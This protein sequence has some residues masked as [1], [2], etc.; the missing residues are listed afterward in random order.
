M[1]NIRVGIVGLGGIAQKA[2]L[3]ILTK[4]TGWELAGAFSPTAEKRDNICRQYRMNSFTSLQALAD[5]CDAVFIHSSTASHFEV[6]STLL[7]KGIDIYVD[8]PLAQT[9]E[10]AEQ[11]VEL[12]EKTGR[13][14]MVGFN[15]RFA[16]SYLKAKEK[17]HGVASISAEKHRI[18]GVGRSTA[19]TI[20]DDYIHLVDTVRWLAGGD[21]KVV[22][23]HMMTNEKDQL[24]HAQHLY[25]ADTQTV[26][27]TA[28]HR[29]AGTNLEQLEVVMDGAVVRVKNM[30]VM[31]EESLGAVTVSNPG[32]WEPVTKLRGF[33][34]AVHHFI[35]S[36][37]QDTRPMPDAL[38]G[39]KTQLAAESLLIG[40]S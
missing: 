19:F 27:A 1:R 15:R 12:S 8:K 22:H 24:I 40:R 23:H 35:A 38:E 28:M 32:S 16:P 36:I 37:Q 33:E 26:Y 30:T 14:V 29:R 7:K 6:A 11:L 17:M 18:N 5:A 13:K 2:Y 9:A 31:E 3:P 34:G 10:Q 20:L 4:E 39:L 25:T 21:L